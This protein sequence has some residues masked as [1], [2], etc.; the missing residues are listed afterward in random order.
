[1]GHLHNLPSH[2]KPSF[3]EG[4]GQ[5]VQTAVSIGAGLKTA[6]DIG[7]TIYSVGRVAAPI[8]AGLL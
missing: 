5:K 3:L 6:Y 1:M 2:K 4:V 7:K 8:I